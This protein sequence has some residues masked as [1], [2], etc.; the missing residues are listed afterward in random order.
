ML[1]VMTKEEIIKRIKQILENYPEIFAATLFGSAVKNRLKPDSDIDIAVAARQPLSYEQKIDLF[2]ALSKVLPREIDLIDLQAVA[3]PILQNALCK[4]IVVKKTS[5]VLFAE[6]IKKMWYN[7]ADMMP[8]S[9]MI[10]KKHCERFI[11]G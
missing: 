6:L 2:L 1:P 4:G 7:Q 9:M 5:T 10:M 8:Y 11:Y 3:G